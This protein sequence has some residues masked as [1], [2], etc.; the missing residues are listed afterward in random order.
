MLFGGMGDDVLVL[1]MCYVLLLFGEYMVDVLC[2]VGYG[3]EVIDVLLVVCVI[4]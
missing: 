2:E 4:F 3:D 1:C